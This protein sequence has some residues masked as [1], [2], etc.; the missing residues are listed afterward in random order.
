MPEQR[1]HPGLLGSGMLQFFTL[2]N[3]VTMALVTEFM[4]TCRGYVHTMDNA[5][6]AVK[7]RINRPRSTAARLCHH[8]AAARSLRNRLDQLF[9]YELAGQ[10]HLPLVLDSR[11]RAGYLQIAT[12]SLDL[13]GGRDNAQVINSC[14]FTLVR[15]HALALAGKRSFSVVDGGK[16]LYRLEGRL[17]I[18]CV[19]QV[20]YTSTCRQATCSTG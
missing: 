3:I 15:S 11:F 4:E 7:A 14:H 20:C 6:G 12:A 8:S 19:L 17:L 10:K 16:L 5:G 9:A 18:T 2:E 1:C 13:G